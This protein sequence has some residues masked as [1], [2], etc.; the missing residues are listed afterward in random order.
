MR[1]RD[2]AVQ[3]PPLRGTLVVVPARD[4]EDEI[5]GA[6]RALATA[7]REASPALPVVVA[8]V[9]HRCGDRTGERA[10][11]VAVATQD[12][13]LRW[14]L[15]ESEAGSLGEA[16]AEGV[17][18]AR[19]AW[20][21]HHGDGAPVDA[22]GLWL[23]STDA[24]SRVPADWLSVQHELAAHGLDLVLGTVVP[25]EDRSHPAADRLWHLQHHL[26]EGHTAVHAANLGVRL[27][28]YDEA[29]GFAALDRSEDAELVH[30]VRVVL[31]VPWASTDRTRV[32]TSSRRE[33]RARGGFA[34]FLR[35]LDDA[36]ETWGDP[37][38]LERLLRGHLLRIAHERGPGRTLCPSEAAAAVDPARRRALTPV[39]RAVACMLADEGLVAVTRRGVV[40][41]GRTTPGPVRVRLVGAP[42]AVTVPDRAT[43]PAP[44]TAAGRL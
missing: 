25:A 23:A 27:S 10:A 14:C 9:L 31:G 2:E 24:D 43:D 39:A 3:R 26:A 1:P 29:G 19:E 15:V 33:G 5:G 22:A 11:E 30:R 12:G 41:D 16:R 18:A 38:T 35:A 7:V 17:A 40:V 32:V 44:S 8:V 20:A 6:L 37:D 42:G 28:A 21:Q 34:R 4:E 36:M 13:R